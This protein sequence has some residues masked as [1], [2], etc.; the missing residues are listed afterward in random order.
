MEKKK[1]YILNS[2]F[3][4]ASFFHILL[5]ADVFIYL[6]IYFAV[7]CST[8]LNSDVMTYDCL[9]FSGTHRTFVTGGSSAQ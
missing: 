6:F 5:A 4:Q 9:V 2:F 7:I 3:R 8:N 1:I